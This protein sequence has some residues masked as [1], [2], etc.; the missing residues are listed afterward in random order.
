MSFKLRLTAH[1]DGIIQEWVFTD[2]DDFTDT[3]DMSDAIINA[4]HAYEVMEE[5]QKEIM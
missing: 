3:E 2:L 1:D 4:V 5:E